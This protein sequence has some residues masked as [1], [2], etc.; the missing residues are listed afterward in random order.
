MDTTHRAGTPLRHRMLNATLTGLKFFFVVPGGELAPDGKTWVACRPAFF[1]PVRV[2]LRLLRRCFLKELQ[3]LQQD[4]KLRFFGEQAGLADTRAFKAWLTPLRKVA[5]VVYAKRPFAGPRAVLAFLPRG[6]CDA[7]PQVIAVR[8]S[9]VRAGQASH[10][11]QQHQ[12]CV[13]HPAAVDHRLFGAGPATSR[14]TGAAG[15]HVR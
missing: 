6:L 1:P 7:C 4:G 3:R 2:L 10:K 15:D 5:W 9:G 14:R 13:A 8:C 11:P 12:P